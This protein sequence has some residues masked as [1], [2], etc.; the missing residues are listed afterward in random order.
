MSTK[1]L[2]NPAPPSSD[3]PDDGPDDD[4]ASDDARRI[5]WTTIATFST[6]TEAHVARL[7]LEANDI[8]CFIADEHT[9]STAWHYSLATGGM[10][11]QVDASDVSRAV[12]RLASRSADLD[13]DVDPSADIHNSGRCARCGSTHIARD[14]FTLR[15]VV[16]LAF[17]TAIALSSHW[18]LAGLLLSGCVL[19]ILRSA[20]YRCEDCHNQWDIRRGFAIVPTARVAPARDDARPN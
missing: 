4:G 6:P 12:E 1:L 14:G 3:P 8:D 20:G 19:L 2:D 16:G 5:R 17:L 11:L 13:N 15:R 10:K 7:L 9:V 18:V